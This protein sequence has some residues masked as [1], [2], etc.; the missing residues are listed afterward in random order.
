MPAPPQFAATKFLAPRLRLDLVPRPQLLGRLRAALTTHALTLVSAPAGYGKSTLLAA[1]PATQPDL[2]L[3]WLTLDEDDNNPAAFLAALSAAFQH[4]DP[5]YGCAAQAVL[6]GQPDPGAEARRVMAA[7]INDVVAAGPDPAILVLDDLHLITEPGL[8]SALDYL[9]ER[10]PPQ[11]HL[12]AAARHDPPLNLAR[13]RARGS[14]AEFRP[15]DLRFSP[16]EASAFLNQSLGLGLSEPEAAAV[17]AR[18]EGWAAGLRLLAASLDRI[19]APAERSAL[20]QRLTATDRYLFDFLAEEVLQRQEPEVRAFLL[21]TSILA[22]LTPDLCQA[23]TGRCDAAAVLRELERRNLF[24]EAVDGAG[25]VFRYHALFAE[26]L[27]QRLAQACPERLANLHGRAAE[28]ETRP[29]R[30]IAHALAGGHWEQAADRLE[31]DGERLLNDGLREALT[32]WIAALPEPTRVARPRLLWL[33]GAGAL[34]RGELEAATELLERAREGF[35]A[36]GQ[37]SGV[38]EALL[39]LVGVASQAHDYPRQASLVQQ[40]LAYPLPTYGR[41]QLLMARAWQALYQG[42]SERADADLEQALRITLTSGEPRVFAVLAPILNMPLAF[43][44][45]GLERLEHYC[46]EVF[47]RYGQSAGPVSA[48]AYSL[49]GY[50]LFL[51]GRLP[52]AVRAA[53]QARALSRSLGGFTYLDVQSHY[54]LGMQAFVRGDYAATLRCWDDLLPGVEQTPSL[55]PFLVSFLFLVGRARW[56]QGDRE[57]ARAAGQRIA[58]LGDPDELPE[59]AISRRLMG[60]LLDI[61]DG[62]YADAE[63]ALV[64]LAAQEREW[65]HG[66]IFGSARVLLASLHHRRG[67][68]DEALAEFEPVLAESERRGMPGLLLQEGPLATPLLRLAVER[69]AHAD[70]ARLVLATLEPGEARPTPVA[71]TGETLTARE[72]EVLRLIAA[73]LSNQAI[74]RRLVIS[75]HTV[76]VHVTNLLAKLGAASR[77]QAAARARELHLV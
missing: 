71:D 5:A 46:R 62:R 30:A 55:R 20:V 17:L 43:L 10:L 54:V 63:R 41:I 77:T 47:N 39:E 51:R 13:L 16:E 66:S 27:R 11:L 6:A 23:V 8:Y 25:T 4:L 65:C 37:P 32:G 59:V 72:V 76:K 29:A 52:E 44:P 24:V 53:E 21:E 58:S 48:G 19:P 64:R 1:L 31:Q 9:L 36:A 42:Q 15:R 14:L 74:A 50:L 67:R 34:Q 35:E 49:S 7:L 33:Q 61:D 38:G 3:A 18:T 56:L 57:Q 2:R 12:A 73:G 45:H 26:F 75:E 40:A 68:P 69:R 22:E 28:A 70:F 60:A